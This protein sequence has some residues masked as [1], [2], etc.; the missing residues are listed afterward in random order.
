MYLSIVFFLYLVNQFSRNSRFGRSKFPFSSATGI[1]CKDLSLLTVLTAD[2]RWSGGNRKNSRLNGNN[3]EIS[4]GV[5]AVWKA[6]FELLPPNLG[7]RG[8]GGGGNA[9]PRQ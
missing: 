3:G 5:F 8:G 9:T 1:R 6:G 7:G 4:G 2:R